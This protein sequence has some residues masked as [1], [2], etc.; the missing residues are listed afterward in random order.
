M[1]PKS[2][3]LRLRRW[4]GYFFLNPKRSKWS[5]VRN[6]EEPLYKSQD[7][8]RTKCV[9][10]CSWNFDGIVFLFDVSNFFLRCCFCCVWFYCLK[11][12]LQGLDLD[13][14]EPSHNLT[15][16]SS[17]VRLSK[18]ESHQMLQ[19]FRLLHSLKLTARTWKWMVEYD[20]FFL[21]WPIFRG[22]CC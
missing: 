6:F 10:I 14:L 4:C 21:G 19:N 16:K 2:G 20:R 5:C 11:S 17:L 1:S 15:A 13:E 3:K 22:V 18:G 9:L 7:W 12:S 8:R